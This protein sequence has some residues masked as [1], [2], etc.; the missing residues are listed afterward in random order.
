MF[1]ETKQLSTMGNSIPHVILNAIE[2]NVLLKKKNSTPK[3][4]LS[5]V[6]CIP[7][8]AVILSFFQSFP[9][10]MIFPHASPSLKH[11][12]CMKRYFV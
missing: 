4:F 7:E 1:L 3:Q 2:I 9:G 12:K 8:E 10:V 6:P 5:P 11:R